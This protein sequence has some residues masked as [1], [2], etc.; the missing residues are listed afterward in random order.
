MEKEKLIPLIKQGL[1]LKEIG[2]YFGIKSPNGIKRWLDKYGLSTDKHITMRKNKGYKNNNDCDWNAIQKYYD[3]GYT[4][5]DVLFKFELPN[6]FLYKAKKSGLFKTRTSGQS[7]KILYKLK[8]I[9]K[10]PIYSDPNYRKKLSETM[11]RLHKEGKHPGWAHINSRKDRRSYPEQMFLNYLKNTEIYNKYRIE[12]KLPIGKYFLDFAI[13]DL[14]LNIEIDGSQHYRNSNSILHDEKRN[15]FLKSKEWKIYRI[16]WADFRN[17][18]KKEISELVNFINDIDNNIDRYYIIE[19]IKIKNLCKFCKK[20]I[21][22]QAKICRCCLSISNRKV[23][24]PSKEDLEK[25]INDKTPWVKMGKMFG[26]TDNSV[27]K[28]C[29]FYSINT[30]K[31]QL[32]EQTPTERE[33]GE[34]ES[35]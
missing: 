23:I 10:S 11:S 8:K 28:W 29:K 20:E 15:Q 7:L 12:E 19:D 4:W 32:V 27:R 1:T 24:R 34:F 2:V 6:T 5:K 13:I 3:E 17:D 25:L 30:S 22:K 26:V 33:D 14:K 35:P 31:A 18:A 9:N 21:G 16:K